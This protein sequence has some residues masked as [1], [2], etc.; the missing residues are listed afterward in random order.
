MKKIVVLLI[1]LFSFCIFSKAY[2]YAV[3]KDARGYTEVMENKN[4]KGEVKAKLKNNT[5]VHIEE[6]D[7]SEGKWVK[8]STRT[9]YIENK[10]YV[11]NVDG[12]IMKDKLSYEFGPVIYITVSTDCDNTI[13]GKLVLKNKMDYNTFNF[14]ADYVQSNA[15]R[16]E[17]NKNIGYSVKK[18]SAEEYIYTLKINNGLELKLTEDYDI[19]ISGL[20][21]KKININDEKIPELATFVPDTSISGINGITIS[22]NK[23]YTIIN[24]PVE[25]KEEGCSI[26]SGNKLFV[27]KDNNFS[28]T[29]DMVYENITDVREFGKWLKVKEKNIAG[30]M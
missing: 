3:I 15:N 27:F 20:K 6:S 10:K 30:E 28:F 1:F 12:Y 5:L 25:T 17:E 24:I 8:I 21:Y 16:Y 2:E 18:D 4:T 19:Y 11:E 22:E 26:E 14:L 23:I 13:L 7:E 9:E 29:A